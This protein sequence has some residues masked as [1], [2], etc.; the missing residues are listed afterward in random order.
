MVHN[1]EGFPGATPYQE[2]LRFFVLLLINPEWKRLAGPC[3]RC[4]AYYIKKRASQKVYCSR[5][6]GNAATAII[7]TREQRQAYHADKLH[8]AA[9]A[10][11]VWSVTPSKLDWKQWVCH[12][13]SDITA[14]FLTR[15]VNTGE[16]KTPV[17]R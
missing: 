2:A 13:H 4:G 5:R 1:C 15:A 7:R 11:S 3:A 8:R 14:K 6:C 9:E 16:L 12:K 17:H 10:A